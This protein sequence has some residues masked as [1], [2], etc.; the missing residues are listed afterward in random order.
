MIASHLDHDTFHIAL[1]LLVASCNTRI[2]RTTFNIDS[3]MSKR[4]HLDSTNCRRW[5]IEAGSAESATSRRVELGS[6][7][8]NLSNL[9]PLRTRLRWEEALY[10]YTILHNARESTTEHPRR[11]SPGGYI[12]TLPITGSSLLNPGS[13][14]RASSLTILTPLVP[15]AWKTELKFSPSICWA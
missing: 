2:L 7:M 5:S 4:P 9:P 12:P 10:G 8:L 1:P 11:V 3:E 15:R 6:C 13:R 14:P